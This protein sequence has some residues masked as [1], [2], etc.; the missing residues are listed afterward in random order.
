[1]KRTVLLGGVLPF[2]SAFLGGVLAFS[3]VVS[4]SATAQPSPAREV[5]AERFV[6]V[7]ADGTE[8]GHWVGGGPDGNA[9]LQLRDAS[10]TLRVLL[11]G[12]GSLIAFDTDGSTIRFRAG[13]VPY[14]DASGRPPINGVWLHP[15]GSISRVPPSP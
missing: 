7:A 12:Q 11:A 10:G 3:L 5:R 4:P 6:L 9:R 15:E 2:V 14:V 8:I 13:Y 1:M